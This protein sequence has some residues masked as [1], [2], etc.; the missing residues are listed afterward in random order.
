ML[1][2]VVFAVFSSYIWH[3]QYLKNRK[4]FESSLV[5]QDISMA[6]KLLHIHITATTFARAEDELF[7]AIDDSQLKS[8]ISTLCSDHQFVI[9]NF[10]QDL[11]RPIE[12]IE[13]MIHQ[14]DNLKMLSL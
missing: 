11:L 10:H 8:L 7:D 12:L 2:Q 13:N 9:D 4:F 3:E 14:N 1:C 6:A 5:I